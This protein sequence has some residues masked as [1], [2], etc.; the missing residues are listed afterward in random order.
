MNS[1][2]TQHQPITKSPISQRQVIL[3]FA[4][5]AVLSDRNATYGEPEDNFAT[6]AN[7]WSSYY[8]MPFTR[9]NVAIMQLLVKVARLAKTPSHTDSWVDIAG[10]AACGGEV[11]LDGA[12]MDR[13]AKTNTL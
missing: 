13:Q 5:T 8:G 12:A 2:T 10:Y 6:I 11:A 7:L 4:A 9:E 1:T 3:D